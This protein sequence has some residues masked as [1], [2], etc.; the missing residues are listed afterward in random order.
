MKYAIDYRSMHNAIHGLI[1]F[2]TRKQVTEAHT[3]LKTLAHTKTEE[4]YN[5]L[6]EEVLNNCYTVVDDLNYRDFQPVMKEFKYSINENG[7][8][9]PVY[10]NVTIINYDQ[11]I[12]LYGM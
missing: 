4:D 7:H 10:D 6:L 8:V 9:H 11:S 1:L 12:D 5:S 3:M 2:N